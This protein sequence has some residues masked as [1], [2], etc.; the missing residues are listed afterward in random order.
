[1]ST[2]SWGGTRVRHSEFRSHGRWHHIAYTHHIADV[3]EEDIVPPLVHTS[4]ITDDL[5]QVDI[6]FSDKTGTLTENQLT[7]QLCCVGETSYGEKGDLYEELKQDL[8]RDVVVQEFVKCICLCHTATVP[9]PTGGG[10]TGAAADRNKF[11]PS[12]GEPIVS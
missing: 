2:T 11:S 7:L 9:L 12:P 6:I 4:G 5:G 1:M 10:G 8:G 3:D